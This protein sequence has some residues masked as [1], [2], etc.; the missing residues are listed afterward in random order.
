MYK[1][2]I[3]SITNIDISH[4]VVRTMQTKY[5][6]YSGL[7]C[8]LFSSTSL[9]CTYLSFDSK[10]D[11]IMDVTNMAEFLGGSFDVAIDKGK[12]T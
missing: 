8:I 3:K 10:E 4:V 5:A 12:L 7:T 9:W 1:D 6:D 2:G 11:S